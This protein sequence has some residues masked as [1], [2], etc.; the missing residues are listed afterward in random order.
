MNTD[1]RLSLLKTIGSEMMFSS[2]VSVVQISFCLKVAETYHYDRAP[3]YASEESTVS[4]IQDQS[5]I[6]DPYLVMRAL[7]FTGLYVVYKVKQGYNYSQE[8]HK[9]ESPLNL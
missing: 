9:D 1:L 4:L 3:N 6:S 7:T 8:E 5:G 2:G